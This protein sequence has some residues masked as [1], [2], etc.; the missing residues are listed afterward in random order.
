MN[1]YRQNKKSSEES[2][3]D[4]NDDQMNDSQHSEEQ[5]QQYESYPQL[6]ITQMNLMEGTGSKVNKARNEY[7]KNTTF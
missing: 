3:E 4:E 7:K 6:N 5:Q 1:L 2:C